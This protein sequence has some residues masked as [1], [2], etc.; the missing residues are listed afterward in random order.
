MI[1]NDEHKISITLHKN[2]QAFIVNSW[3]PEFLNIIYKDTNVAL[4]TKRCTNQLQLS[5]A[6]CSPSS[7]NPSHLKPMEV[8]KP[9]RHIFLP[10]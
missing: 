8:L 3:E 6:L 4:H 2:D 9:T 1:L 10:F 7:I 5:E